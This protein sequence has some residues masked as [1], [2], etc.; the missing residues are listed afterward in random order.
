M[1]LK[2]DDYCIAPIHHKD[3]WRLCDFVVSNSE[4]LK[5]YFPK[6]LK[7]NLTP[8]LAELFVSQKV[9]EF[10]NND[11]YLF[12]VKENTN[13]TIIGLVYLKELH[14]APKQAEFAYCISYRYEG[15][16]LSAKCIDKLTDWAFQEADLKTLQIIVHKENIASIR[17]AEKNGFVF[18][19][20][21]ENEHQVYNGDWVDMELYERYTT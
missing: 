21:L 17:A 15:K 7:A 19:K 8:T 14:K 1:E 11:E 13:R 10:Q 12:T 2:F 9:K 6:T 3:T 18:K 16:G 5:N 4:R 20:S